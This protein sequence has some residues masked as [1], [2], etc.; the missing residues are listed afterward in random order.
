MTTPKPITLALLLFVSS[1]LPTWASVSVNNPANESEVKSPF[2]LSAN[3]ESCSSEPVTSMSYSLDGNPDV[4]V[5]K[6]NSL[7]TKVVSVPGTHTLHVKAL[8]EK[9]SVCVSDI[10]L[11]VKADDAASAIVP[12]NATAVHSIQALRNWIG[13]HD[14]G[15]SGSASGSTSIVSSPSLNGGTRRFSTQFKGSG[16]ERFSVSYADDKEAEN[17]FYDA[18]VYIPSSSGPISNIEMDT[19]QVIAS[20]QTVILG[21]QCDGWSGTWTFTANIGSPKH[22]RPH[23]EVAPGTRC[24]PESWTKNKWHHVQAS[25]S[26][27]SSGMVTYHSAWV[28]GVE[29]VLNR[30]VPGAFD[31][32]WGSDINTQFQIDGRGSSGSTT[33]YVDDLTISRW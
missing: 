3:S 28:D 2:A 12:G 1:A 17:F 25:Y 11:T 19:N 21:V 4:E 27:N 16:D 15:G 24:D 10:A 29:S 14:T 22:P 30:T 26:R 8:G 6:G 13:M 7:E 32:G 5:L 20:G 18:W 31:L 23:W 9:G 33:V